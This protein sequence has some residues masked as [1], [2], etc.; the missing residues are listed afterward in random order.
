MRFGSITGTLLAV[1]FGVTNVNA[2]SHDAADDHIAAAKSAARDEHVG[3][4]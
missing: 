3:C 1:S 4:G 2:Q